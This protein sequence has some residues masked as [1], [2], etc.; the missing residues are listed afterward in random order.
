MGRGLLHRMLMGGGGGG[1]ELICVAE[2][3]LRKLLLIVRGGLIYA[4]GGIFV[5]FYGNLLLSVA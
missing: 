5:G 1:G 3:T 2:I 4:E